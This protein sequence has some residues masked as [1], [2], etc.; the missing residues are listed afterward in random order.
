MCSENIWSALGS[1]F[2][3]SVF[4]V[5]TAVPVMAATP[6]ELL[7]KAIYTE[8][9]VGDLD[10]A[11]KLYEQVIADGKAVQETA[12]QAQYRLALCLQKKGRDADARA[13]FQALV[14]NFP[15]ATDLVAQ[16]RKHLSG[17]IELLKAPW[18]LGDRMQLNMSLPSGLELGTMVYMIDAANS[19]AHAV[20]DVVQCSTRGLVTVNGANSF[21]EVLCKAGNFAPIRSLWKHSLLG[22]AI[23]TYS[24]TSV[25]VEVVGKDK[26]FT[27]DFTPPAFDN[28]QCVELF[29]RLPLAEG[30]KTT[31]TVV[32]SLGGNK[33]DLGVEV[34]AKETL[35]VP[36]GTFECYKLLLSIGQ[37]FWVSADEHRY[38]VRFA[39][40]G[41]TADLAKVWNANPDSEEILKTAYFTVTLPSGWLNYQPKSGEESDGLEV[42]LLDPRADARSQINAR[43]KTKLKATEQASPKVWTESF[44]ADVKKMYGDFQVDRAGIVE[45]TIGGQKAAQIVANFSEG[46]KQYRMLGVAVIGEKSAAVLRFTTEADQFDSLRKDFDAIV[47]SFQ[48]E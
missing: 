10:Q 7:E 29:R 11:M 21:S 44:V 47:A 39:A 46:G 41:V 3:T 14:D 26:Q 19:D 38:V 9:T 15:T 12:A 8:E 32:T 2:A 23:A 16:A 30:Y 17:N 1:I 43:P 13:A 45:T 42:I 28:E 31:L 33:L 25:A 24:D 37:T 22:E 4:L 5:V 27:I 35:T 34:A 40:G 20:T 48:L 18:T 6:G 36:A